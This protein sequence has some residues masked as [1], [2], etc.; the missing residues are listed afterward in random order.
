MILTQ[1]EMPINVFNITDWGVDL[2]RFQDTLRS[3][4]EQYAWD[5]YL[6]RQNQIEY[7]KKH[8]PG[9]I[10]S[11]IEN[12]FWIDFYSGKAPEQQIRKLVE[13]LPADQIPGYQRIKK[14][15]KRLI[16]EFN[17]RYDGF[18]RMERIPAR[19]FGQEYALIR[20]RNSQDYRL[21]K[22]TFA[23][24]PESLNNS[25]MKKILFGIAEDLAEKNGRISFLNI[26]VHP[27]L[28]YCFADQPAS[29]SPEGIHQDGMDYIVSALVMER[30]D[31]I[32]GKSVVYG[33]DIR[34]KI[35][36]TVLQA[37]QGI[38]QPDKDTEL[39]HEVTP[40]RSAAGFESGYR[41]TIG[42]DITVM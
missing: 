28:L 36:E 17:I 12:S 14:T 38:L 37:G 42:F 23:E 19:A 15:R 16:A 3:H 21:A 31:V 10:L 9:R 41:S 29:N 24:M 2:N 40:I 39:W 27:T 6:Y 33:K 5:L 7:L 25:D 4:Y 11:T 13:R 34:T 18:W 8:L 32:G 35:L 22:R 20:D 1:L 30:K 26:I